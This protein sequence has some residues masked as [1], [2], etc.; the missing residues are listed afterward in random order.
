MTDGLGVGRPVAPDVDL[1]EVE[2][3]GAHPREKSRHVGQHDVPLT[4][5]RI[6]MMGEM[7]KCSRP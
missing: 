5:T 2:P 6:A 3:I 1:R 7:L 4:Y